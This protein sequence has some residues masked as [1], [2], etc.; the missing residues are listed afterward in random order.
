MLLA[1]KKHFT[2][3]TLNNEHIHT[4]GLTAL[5][6][7]LYQAIKSKKI[8]EVK[9]LLQQGAYTQGTRN[10]QMQ[11]PLHYAAKYKHQEIFEFLVDYCKKMNIK[12]HFWLKT[13]LNK[14]F[15]IN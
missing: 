4:A 3:N 1:C 6:R 11:S 15:F 7:N 10:E 9:E 8:L 13:V 12:I 5:E 14:P 2:C